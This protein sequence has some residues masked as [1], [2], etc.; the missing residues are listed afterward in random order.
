MDITG[1]IL[2]IDLSNLKGKYTVT[3]QYSGDNNYP[4]FKKDVKATIQTNPSIT[5]SPSKALYSAGTTYK[6]TVYKNKGITANGVKVAIKLNGKTFKTPKTNSKG[7]VSFKI[8]QK[9]GTYKVKITALGKSVT[10]T[11]T[12]KHILTLKTATLKKSAKK[13][14]LQ[15]SLAKVNGKKVATA[16]TNKKGVAKITIKNPSVVKKLKVGKKVSYTATYSKDTVKK[17]AKIKK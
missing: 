2:K 4:A 1:G 16:K 10:K 5:A 17:T 12:V 15:A 3:F 6:I 13:L 7:V 9:P 8:T 14:T 11:I